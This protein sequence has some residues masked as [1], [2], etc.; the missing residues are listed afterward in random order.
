MIRDPIAEK[1][2]ASRRL[3]VVRGPEDPCSSVYVVRRIGVEPLLRVMEIALIPGMAAL[4]QA[5][6]EAQA[7]VFAEA[8]VPQPKVEPESPAIATLQ[9]QFQVY[10]DKIEPLLIAAIEGIGLLRSDLE[11]THRGLL[12]AGTLVEDVCIDLTGGAEHGPLYARPLRLVPGGH[13]LAADELSLDEMHASERNALM[14]GVMEVVIPWQEVKPFPATEQP[15]A[16]GGRLG[17][18]LRPAAAR[19]PGTRPATGRSAGGGPR[20][21]RAPS[22]NE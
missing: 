14:D 20:P 10:R 17:A 9:Q 15:A 5:T 12:P 13:D 22:R 6:P 7:Q 1:R 18:A 11:A 8:G 19:A 16:H 21:G 2:A 4:A 3:V